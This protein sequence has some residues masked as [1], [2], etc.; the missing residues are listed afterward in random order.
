[1]TGFLPRFPAFNPVA[2]RRVTSLQPITALEQPQVVSSRLKKSQDVVSQCTSLARVSNDPTV[3]KAALDSV[4]RS[5]GVLKGEDISTILRSSAR[6]GHRDELMLAATCESIKT[7]PQLGILRVRDIASIL[8]SFYK[9]NFTPSVETLNSLSAEILRSLPLYRTRNQDLCLLFRYF[10]VLRFNPSLVINFDSGFKHPYIAD[11]LERE[12]ENRLGQFGPLELSIIAKYSSRISLE[13]LMRNYSRSQHV[14]IAVKEFFIRQLD[15]RFG[16]NAWMAYEYLLTPDTD[17]TGWNQSKPEEDDDYLGLNDDKKFSLAKRK[18]KLPLFQL[19]D[20]LVKE[21]LDTVKE[22]S[23][24]RKE[25][26]AKRIESSSSGSELSEQQL[27]FIRSLEEEFAEVKLEPLVPKAFSEKVSKKPYRD[28]ELSESKQKPEAREL[29]TM[30]EFK[31]YRR[32]VLARFAR[33]LD[34]PS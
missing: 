28:L 29:R 5:I 3:W 27:E 32:R 12:I 13:S 9:L 20:A 15:N 21:R 33:L 16:Q 4:T 34:S 19:D 18:T 7:M 30:K 8:T 10:S 23:S 2:M 14:P 17:S 25:S 26:I 24:R 1:M 22:T 31:N 6:S 11:R